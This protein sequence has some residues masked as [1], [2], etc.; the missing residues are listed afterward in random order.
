MTPYEAKPKQPS[1][2]LNAPPVKPV[3]WRVVRP[4]THTEFTITEPHRT[5][6]AARAE[7]A[8]RLGCDPMDLRC[9]VAR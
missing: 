7:A 9:E 2:V 4:G 8:M 5:A 3:R 6:H 1:R